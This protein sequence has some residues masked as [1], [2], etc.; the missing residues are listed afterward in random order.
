MATFTSVGLVACCTLVLAF[1][2]ESDVSVHQS[3][4][5]TPAGE[6]PRTRTHH[7]ACLTSARRQA[8]LGAHPPPRRLLKLAI[9]SGAAP[10]SAMNCGRVCAAV[11]ALW[12][13]PL[14]QPQRSQTHHLCHVSIGQ[15]EFLRHLRT[16]V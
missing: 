7:H 10:L 5:G 6:Y 16:I 14:P 9:H 12:V 4:Y 2:V 11:E 15:P 13:K 8:K 3:T 1:S